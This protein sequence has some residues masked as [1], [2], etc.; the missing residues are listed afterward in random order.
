MSDPKII[1]GVEV[2][3][4]KTPAVAAAERALYQ[5]DL[6]TF[7][8]QFSKMT[9]DEVRTSDPGFGPEGIWVNPAYVNAREQAFRSRGLQLE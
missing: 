6:A 3:G 7:T 1:N 4:F 5:R 9:N 8:E 2:W